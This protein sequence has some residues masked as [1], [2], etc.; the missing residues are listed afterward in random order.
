[1]RGPIV[2]H[3]AQPAVGGVPRYL[4]GLARDQLA[5]GWQVEVAAPPGASD[6]GAL[7]AEGVALHPWSAQAGPG[8][9]LARELPALARVISRVGPDVVHLHSSKAGLAGRL[10]L[11]GRRPTLFQPN[12]WSFLAVDGLLRRGSLAWER[13]GAR[14][15]HLTICVS[16][17]E[18]RV[19]LAA[20]IAP[21]M[22][23]VANG[24]D[25]DRHRPGDER[26]RRDARR[27]LDL[28]D[29][30][31]VVCVG[32]LCRQKGQDVLLDAWPAVRREVPSA[33]LAL[34]GDGPTEA[35]LRARGADGVRLVGHS[36]EVGRWLRAADLLAMPSRW[37][38]M[39][40]ALLEAMACGLAVVASDVEGAREALGPDAGAI[41]PV[42]DREALAAAI[43]QR[44]GDPARRAAEGAAARRRA[45]AGHDLRR[46]HERVAQL[47]LELLGRA[48][49][50]DGVATSTM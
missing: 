19:G 8:P 13:A 46:H 25:L 17:D 5:R 10:A 36:D 40:F 21:P 26:A 9:G 28:P 33:R 18:R 30:P 11:R 14:W 32:R 20:G 22:A 6:L 23:V 31:L 7:A 15:S 48:G 16:E 43:V 1:M 12:G 41:V 42:A 24:V 38:G 50:Q 34:V 44:L 45:E 29:G 47:T 3:V 49:A 27:R 39:S 4:A 2:L 37:E 35:E